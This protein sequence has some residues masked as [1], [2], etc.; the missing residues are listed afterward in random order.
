MNRDSLLVEQKRLFLQWL[1][2]FGLLVFVLYLAWREEVIQIIWETDISHVTRV[3]AVVFVVATLHVGYRAYQLAREMDEARR[4]CHELDGSAD[5]AREIVGVA[6]E[7][8]SNACY[9][10]RHL[11]ALCRK[12]AVADLDASEVEQ[13]HLLGVLEKRI[14][15][16]H[17]MGWF[18]TDLMLK[19]GLLGTVIGFI[20]MLGAVSSVEDFDI[21]IMQNLLTTMS[22]GM[23]VALFTTLSGLLAGVLLGFQYHLLDRGANE[24]LV[25][26]T[27]LSEVYFLPAFLSASS[28]CESLQ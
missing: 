27:E 20:L 7:E 25:L 13:S 18:V 12:L 22:E 21:A 16:G 14:R 9:A 26:I 19:L 5:V 8:I 3:I 10:R 1:V 11:Y 4:L 15:A 17:D 6:T 24:L 23:R 2:F 28:E